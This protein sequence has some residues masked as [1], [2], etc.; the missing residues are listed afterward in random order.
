[1]TD[2]AGELTMLASRRLQACLWWMLLV[3]VTTTGSSVTVQDRSCAED[4]TCENRDLKDTAAKDAPSSVNEID[5]K[6][7][8][9][10][11]CPIDPSTNIWKPGDLNEC[12]I[13]ITTLEEYKQ[14]KP[15]VLSRP[16]YLSE[17]T[18]DYK[19]GPWVVMLEDFISEQETERLIELGAFEGYKQSSEVGKRKSSSRTSQNSWCQHDCYKDPVSQR[20]NQRIANLTGIPEENAEFLYVSFLA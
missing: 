13:N 19:V 14:Y 5:L 16:E 10:D 4:G 17:E 2:L 7:P 20:I 15:N 3:A 12:F 18:A 6:P 9:E 11:R 8:I 1:M